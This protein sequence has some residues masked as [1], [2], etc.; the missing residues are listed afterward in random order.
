[1]EA[2]RSLVVFSEVRMP[3]VMRLHVLR[4]RSNPTVIDT[5]EV[6]RQS[7]SVEVAC[8]EVLFVAL[9]FVARVV[10]GGVDCFMVRFFVV[11]GSSTSPACHRGASR[12]RVKAGLLIPSTL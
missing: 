9:V 11:R 4:P 12:P 7:R 1:M 2:G 3:V 6:A 10:A 8:F 5:G